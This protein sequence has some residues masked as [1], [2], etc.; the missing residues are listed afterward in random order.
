M[1]TRQGP[2]LLTL[3]EIEKMLDS[4]VKYGDGVRPSDV[5]SVLATARAAMLVVE[6]AKEASDE[7]QYAHC[8]HANLEE[9]L[10]PFRESRKHHCEQC[11][12]ESPVRFCSMTCYSMSL[13]TEKGGAND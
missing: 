6:A 9:Y 4:E 5:L 7:K 2:K 12:D 10:K 11:G 13:A 8:W 1:T 3:E